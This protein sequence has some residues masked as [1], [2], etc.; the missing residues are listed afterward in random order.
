[1]T[2]RSAAPP[3]IPAPM[4]G[5]RDDRGS[6]TV[7]WV[8]LFPLVITFLLA[9][10]QVGM[11]YQARA[12][13]RGAALEGARVAAAETATLQDGLATAT[14]FA[15]A[16]SDTLT[17]A[18]VTG[19]RSATEATITV[20]GVSGQILPGYRLTITQVAIMPVERITG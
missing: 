7:A 17:E 5:W 19:S 8:I 12:V 10:V 9:A 15:A 16:S 13:A 4:R 6:S 14:S 18:H 1:M 3:V 2:P 20:T 11:L